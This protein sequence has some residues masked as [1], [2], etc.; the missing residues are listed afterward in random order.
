MYNPFKKKEQPVK[1]QELTVATQSV[2]ETVTNEYV[3]A[4]LNGFKERFSPRA[5]KTVYTFVNIDSG[6]IFVGTKWEMSDNYPE[7]NVDTLVRRTKRTSKRWALQDVYS[8]INLEKLRKPFSGVHS[9]AAD[10][11]DYS[12]TNLVTGEIFLGSRCALEASSG[13]NVSTLF[14]VPAKITAYDWCLTENLDAAKKLSRNDYNKYMFIH[15]DGR[16][17]FGTRGEFKK[18]TGSATWTLF[19]K[20]SNKTLK[21]W[22]LAP[23]N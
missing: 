19:G 4:L 20:R 2:L 5:D 12:F 15:K 23:H 10:K 8:S 17:F 22:A 13:K 9:P 6:S 3:D 18:S 7:V 14:K 1:S 11:A 16:E 21:G